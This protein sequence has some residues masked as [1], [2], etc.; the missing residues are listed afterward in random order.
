MKTRIAPT[1]SGYLHLG[2]ALSFALTAGTG[3]RILLRIDDMDRD[4]V[5]DAYVQDIFDTLRFLEIPWDE[6]P[7]D[8]EDY[9]KSWAQVHRLGLYHAALERL[10]AK[11]AVFAC[12]CSRSQIKNGMYPGTCREKHIPLDTEGASWRLRTNAPLPPDM[13]DF[14]VRKKDGFPSYQ[15]T[16]VV[17]DLHYGID[18]VVRGEDL[19]PS[20]LAQQYLAQV[21]EEQAF[22]GI[23]FLHHPLLVDM[24]GQKL[25][26]SAGST[27]IQ[28]MR[29]EGR[30]A[31]E[32]YGNIGRLSRLNEPVDSWRTLAA[33]FKGL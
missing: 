11:N 12:T 25:S 26:K 20:T 29:K 6:G 1:P 8:L 14:V 16:S 17:D 15:L 31:R 24:D 33:A 13:Q 19:R 5:S 10:R 18:L 7:L 30:T 21:L 23:L 4:R 9:K 22:S 28:A 3:A 27:S 32:V 2:N